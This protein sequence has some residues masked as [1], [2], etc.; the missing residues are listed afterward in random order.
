MQTRKNK[1]KFLDSEQHLALSEDIRLE[2]R[3]QFTDVDVEGED[4]TQRSR[5]ENV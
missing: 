4:V 5:T 2:Y 3:S 1:K